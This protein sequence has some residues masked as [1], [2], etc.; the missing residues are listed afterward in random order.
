M[1]IAVHHHHIPRRN[2]VVP[3]NFVGRGCAI[4]DEIAVISVENPRRIALAG[5]DSAVV[6]QQ[7][8]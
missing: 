6:I 7:L 3:H 8:P 5:T 2:A 1:A 4:G